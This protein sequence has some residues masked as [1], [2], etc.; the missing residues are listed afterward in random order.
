MNRKRT[1]DKKQ[2]EAK[3]HAVVPRPVAAQPPSPRPPVS[4]V[5]PAE[6]PP[7]AEVVVPHPEAAF[8][9]IDNVPEELLSAGE[10]EEDELNH[11]GLDQQLPGEDQCPGE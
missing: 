9:G 11:A 6:E 7:L 3:P 2:S 5:P 10:R 8:G 1:K 4:D